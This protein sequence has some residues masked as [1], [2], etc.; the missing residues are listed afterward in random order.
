MGFNK[1][2]KEKVRWCKL[3]EVIAMGW[4]GRD[5]METGWSAWNRN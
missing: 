3:H 5:L 2:G 4:D 1:S